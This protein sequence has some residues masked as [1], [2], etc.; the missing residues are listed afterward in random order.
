MQATCTKVHGSPPHLYESRIPA[1]KSSGLGIDRCVTRSDDAPA[2][3]T[4]VPWPWR[5]ECVSTRH[6]GD[7]WWKPSRND[8]APRHLL[9]AGGTVAEWSGFSDSRW[10][11]RLAMLVEISRPAGVRFLTVHP[12]EWHDHERPEVAQEQT[13]SPSGPT[14]RIDTELEGIRVVVDPVVDGRERIR[15][16]VEGWPKSRTLNEKNLGRALFGDAGEPDLV[17]VLGPSHC[18]PK[19]LVWELAYGELVFIDSTWAHLGSEH[20]RAAIDE[21]SS[22]Q[23]RFGGV[24]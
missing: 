20:V 11:E 8:V 13:F 1:V 7:V 17:V 14:R 21:F 15:A 19:S 4:E 18:L 3:S 23:R 2:R 10:Q 5:G 6:N 22:R 24:E 12:H 9:V 16:A